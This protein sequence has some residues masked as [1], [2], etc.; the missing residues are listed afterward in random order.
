MW[1]WSLSGKFICT[2]RTD[3]YSY[4]ASSYAVGA[5]ANH[6]VRFPGTGERGFPNSIRSK[7]RCRASRRLGVL[8]AAPC[9]WREHAQMKGAGELGIRHEQYRHRRSGHRGH[10]LGRRRLDLRVVYRRRNDSWRPLADRLANAEAGAE[11]SRLPGARGH[12]ALWN[13]RRRIGTA[14]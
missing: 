8:T 2:F 14:E 3:S 10:A 1:P 11:I 6:L 4:K 7:P 9:V 12:A 13:E 5:T